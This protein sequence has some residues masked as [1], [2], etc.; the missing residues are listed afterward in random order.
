MILLGHKSLRYVLLYAQLSKVYEHGSDGYIC[1]EAT[2]KA[3]A[4]AL[5][6]EGFEFV[7]DK[8]RASLFRKLK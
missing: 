4:K 3:E 5:I 6:E 1:R 8:G 2:N 7:T